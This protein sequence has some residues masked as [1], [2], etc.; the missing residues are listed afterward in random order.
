MTAAMFT[1]ELPVPPSTNN[2]F[3]NVGKRRVA[4]DE[5]NA[6]RDLAGYRLNLQHVQP[7]KGAVEIDMAVP[8]NR[9]RDLDNFWKATLDLLVN[10]KL[11]ED[12]RNIERLTL[13]WHDEKREAVVIVRAASKVVA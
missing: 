2:L 13:A 12:D 8:R 11:I 3:V 10:H 9:R 1:V 4:S 6:W 7:I 5:Y